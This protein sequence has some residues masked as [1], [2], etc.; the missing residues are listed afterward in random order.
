MPT[1]PARAIDAPLS[2]LATGAAHDLRNLLFVIRAHCDHLIEDVAPHDSRYAD[3]EAIRD[4]ADRGAVLTSQLVAAGRT[5]DPPRP[6]DVTETIR[7]FEPLIRRLVG[8]RVTVAM[9]LAATSWRVTANSVQIEQIVMNLAL[10]ARDA[11][12]E[13]GCLTIATENRTL[14]GTIVG[15]PA[16]FVE[17]SVTDSGEGIDPTI[18]HRIF[19]PYFTTK[20]ADGTGVGLATVRV[21]AML[22]GGHVEVITSPDAGTTMRVVLP[23]APSAAVRADTSAAIAPGTATD[24]RRILL[25][26]NERAIGDYLQRALAAEGYDVSVVAS[27]AEALGF[28]ELQLQPVDVIVTDVHLPDLAGPVVA[29]RLRAVWPGVGLVFMSGDSERLG[30]LRNRSHAP[31]LAKP[32]TTA[33]LVSAVRTALPAKRRE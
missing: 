16:Q 19:E 12:P 4:A 6:A 2:S 10:N 22:N 29:N 1:S 14:A 9:R 17:I 3:L 7:K 27:G 13:G 28:C 23:R 32:F 26:E 21:I 8:D 24:R 30:E 5:D 33:E 15:Q 18:Q 31:V 20:G 25:I 11:M